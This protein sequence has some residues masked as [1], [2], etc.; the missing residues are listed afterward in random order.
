MNKIK[1]W[2]DLEGIKNGKGLSL[3]VREFNKNTNFFNCYVIDDE[4]TCILLGTYKKCNMAS[5]NKQVYKFGFDL[6]YRE[7]FNLVNFLRQNIEPKSYEDDEDGKNYCFIISNYG[8][9]VYFGDYSN[10]EILNAVYFKQKEGALVNLDDVRGR[11][12][13]EKITKIKLIEALKELGWI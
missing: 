3:V 2:Q 8:L 9:N 11:L 4:E 5:M 1:S 12:L 13:K 6:E 7:P 10:H